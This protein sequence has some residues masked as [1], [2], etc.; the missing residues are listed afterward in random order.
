METLGPTYDQD[1]LRQQSNIY[2]DV[3]LLASC[4]I[5]IGVLKH[6]KSMSDDAS[7]PLPCH[8]IY[9]LGRKHP[10]FFVAGV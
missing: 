2:L 3:Q 1:R 6:P 8:C 4:K 9:H 5:S 7:E 10:R